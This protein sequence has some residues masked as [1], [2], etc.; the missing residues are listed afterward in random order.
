VPHCVTCW[1]KPS[2]VLV[3]RMPSEKAGRMM[4]F[5][6]AQRQAQASANPA[7]AGCRGSKEPLNKD[8][9]GCS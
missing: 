2:G 3:F 7:G 1:N 8:R 9:F 5:A 4:R 6:S